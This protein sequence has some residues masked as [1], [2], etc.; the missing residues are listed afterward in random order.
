MDEGWRVCYKE[1]VVVEVE[2]DFMRLHHSVFHQVLFPPKREAENLKAFSFLKTYRYQ[3][4]PNEE[5]L[6]IPWVVFDLETTG[7]H[8]HA[9]RIIEVGAV[10]FLGGREVGR[11]SSLVKADIP[12]P[13]A[14]ERLTGITQEMLVDQRSAH[15]VIAEFIEFLQSSLLVCHNSAFDM[16]MLGAE[17]QRQNI[18]M[19]YSCLCTLKMAREVLV[20]LPNKKLGTLAEYFA[21]PY[22]TRHR[23]LSDARVTGA[24]LGK[25][26]HLKPE[27]KT[28][29]DALPYAHLTS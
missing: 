4:R 20:H 16:G 7:L 19:D 17:L 2:E 27:L 8:K 23:S 6:G 10:K 1:G 15:E 14:V 28:W 18:Q 3:I 25:M 24:V 5:L 9:D 13:P 21:L 26:L 29:Q 22:E 11:F 12:I